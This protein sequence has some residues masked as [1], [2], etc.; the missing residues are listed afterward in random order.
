VNKQPA[1]RHKNQD[2]QKGH[3]DLLGSHHHSYK[4]PQRAGYRM[5]GLLV[6]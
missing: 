6:F 2:D 1:Q 5:N 3:N 4:H